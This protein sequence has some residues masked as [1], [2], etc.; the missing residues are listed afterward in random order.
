[1]RD[2]TR[3]VSR[4]KLTKRSLPRN[5][6]KKSSRNALSHL[7]PIKDIVLQDLCKDLGL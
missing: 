7:K 3:I 4:S 5:I 2:Y 6:M 1:M